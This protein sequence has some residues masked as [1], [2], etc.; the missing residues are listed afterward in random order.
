MV[1]LRQLRYL[2]ALARHGHFGRAAEACAVTQP[3]LSMQISDLERRLGV[4]VVERRPGEVILTDAGREIARRGDAVLTASRDLVD[5]ARHR[6]APLTGRL[7]LGVIPSLAPYL[8]PKILPQLQ[9]QFPELRLELRESQ[10]RQLVGEIKSGVLD[11]ALLALPAGDDE[12]DAIALFEDLFLL[13]VPADDPR[14]ETVPVAVGAI[15]QSRLILLE[16][17]HCL[18]DQALAFCATARRQGGA[19]SAM[20]FGASSL[21]TVIQMVAGGYGTTLIPQI[22]AEVERRDRRVKFL[23]LQA[24]QPG[25]SI[26]L[27]Y[28][29]TS[30]RKADFSALGEV[31]KACVRAADSPPAQ[32]AADRRPAQ[33]RTDS[34]SEP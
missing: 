30:P 23:S 8:L 27:V 11:A 25:R 17:G 32:G 10:T 1:T 22:A 19:A 12:L 21:T 4:K 26:G 28:R 14:P 2:S 24:P 7:T 15:D 6:A 5:F 13:A 33:N 34:A 9:R 20:A 31:V 29:R 18:R 16:D 3:A